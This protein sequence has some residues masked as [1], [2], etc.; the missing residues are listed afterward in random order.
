MA[1][2][3]FDMA[4]TLQKATKIGRPPGD[5]TVGEAL[6]AVDADQR[7]NQ[8]A[9]QQ[10]MQ[11]KKEQLLKE[12]AARGWSLN[13]VK[14]AGLPS[15]GGIGARLLGLVG[16]APKA[17]QAVEPT[18]EEYA[19]KVY[20]MGKAATDAASNGGQQM[21]EKAANMLQTVGPYRMQELYEKFGARDPHI[22]DQI[23]NGR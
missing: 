16:L 10:Q 17:L 4:K 8:E 1:D 18:V 9:E 6:Y 13:D 22:L 19:P 12:M 11:Q 20:E 14:Q 2:N 23:L 7:K 15:M 5:P 21:M 3:T